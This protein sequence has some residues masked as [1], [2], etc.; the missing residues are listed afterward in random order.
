M[1]FDEVLKYTFPDLWGLGQGSLPSSNVL[2]RVSPDE[3][4][5]QQSCHLVES[6]LGLLLHLE[7][8]SSTLARGGQGLCTPRG[9]PLSPHLGT[10][11]HSPVEGHPK[12]RPS[13]LFNLHF[14]ETEVLR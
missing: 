3:L 4:A 8:F 14:S 13:F 9:A 6:H 1:A 12:E 11:H 2:C 7:P 10:L 5:G